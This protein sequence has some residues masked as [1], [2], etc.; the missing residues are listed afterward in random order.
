M[1][2]MD[3]LVVIYQEVQKEVEANF[4]ALEEIYSLLFKKVEE[5]VSQEGD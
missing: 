5:I 2:P 1:I 4:L 3:N